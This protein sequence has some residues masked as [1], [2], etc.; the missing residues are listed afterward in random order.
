MHLLPYR[1][2]RKIMW[3]FLRIENWDFYSNSCF[4][5]WFVFFFS[6]SSLWFVC[7]F[8]PIF[9]FPPLPPLPKT[10]PG[11]HSGVTDLKQL[12]NDWWKTYFGL[13]VGMLSIQI[14]WVNSVGAYVGKQD[15]KNGWAHE[16]ASDRKVISSALIM[17]RGYCVAH[18]FAQVGFEFLFFSPLCFWNDGYFAFRRMVCLS[19]WPDRDIPAE[20]NTGAQTMT[21]SVVTSMC[22]LL[23]DRRENCKFLSQEM[24][25][26]KQ[27][28][29]H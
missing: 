22:E 28:G 19:A 1:T 5:F 29:Q 4:Y 8:F 11:T 17:M 20:I 13:V 16:H 6:G 24:Q 25:N 18:I 23:S 10:V 12:Q 7:F 3:P 21:C 27:E 9:L 26:M 15:T 14:H 2:Q